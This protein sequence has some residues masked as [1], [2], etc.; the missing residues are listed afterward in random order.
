MTENT[1]YSSGVLSLIAAGADEAVPSGI[2]FGALA[3]GS[4][5]TAEVREWMEQNKQYAIYVMAGTRFESDGVP[6]ISVPATTEDYERV[7]G[8]MP[9]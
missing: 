7:I 6:A 3:L 2:P 5:D 9:R 4:L 1:T 8:A